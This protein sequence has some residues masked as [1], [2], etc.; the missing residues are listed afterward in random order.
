MTHDDLF[1]AVSALKRYYPNKQI[2]ITQTTED[3]YGFFKDVDR[4]DFALAVGEWINTSVYFPMVAD[5]K[6][7]INRKKLLADS[8]EVHTSDHMPLFE[9]SGC[10]VCPYLMEGQCEPCE[11]CMFEGG[12]L[13]DDHGD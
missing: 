13:N 2:D 8:D 3:W 5:L 9:D 4:N 6:D 12:K 1:R 11:S 7:I 10:M